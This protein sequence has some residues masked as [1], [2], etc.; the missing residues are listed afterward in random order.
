MRAQIVGGKAVPVEKP[1]LSEKKAP[2]ESSRFTGAKG[3]VQITKLS[4]ANG[5]RPMCEAQCATSRNQLKSNDAE[6][7]FRG[8]LPY[9]EAA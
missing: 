5:A 7:I 3:R 8:E 1:S 6:G 4:A 2:F 9:E